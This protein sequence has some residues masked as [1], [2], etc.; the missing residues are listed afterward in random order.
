MVLAD[1]ALSQAQEVMAG[2][3]RV[4][5]DEFGIEHTTIQF[6]GQSC[7]QG[8][9]V[10]VGPQSAPNGPPTLLA[11]FAHP[12][13]E[14]F[15]CGGTLALLVRRGVRVQVLTATRGQAGDCG[16]P[17]LCTPEELP[18]V[19]DQE[20]RCACAALGIEP[21]RILDY[22]DGTLA[23]VDAEGLIAAILDLVREVHPQVMLSFGPDG[24]SG[25][26]DHIAIGRC[27]AE[28]FRRASDVAELYTVAVPRS[29]AERL[30]MGRVR[31]VPDEE[32]AL[33]VDAMPVWEQKM[34]AMRCHATQGGASPLT[35][36]PEEQ[37][38]LFF[39]TEHFVRAAV[40][41]PER[42]FLGAVLRG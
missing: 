35:Q 23:E 11:V 28:A 7:G 18:A 10:C 5:A 25:H 9:V 14:T 26:P 31:S 3:K 32:I 19:R 2:L 15:R 12:D 42:D 24:L 20:L 27:A 37:Q 6:E 36:A 8:P 1:Q 41:Q 30:G 40:R 38:R 17:P 4:L 29:V 39:G 22:R 21:P 33:T 16:D 13:D 34:A